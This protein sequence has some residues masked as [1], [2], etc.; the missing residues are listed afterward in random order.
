MEEAAEPTQACRTCRASKPLSEFDVRADTGKPSTQ[1]RDCRRDY[2]REWL[3]GQ[4]PPSPPR[5]PRRLGAADSFLCSRCGQRKP[6]SEFP[7]RKRG[8]AKLQSWCR[9][10]F[11][12][13]GARHYA[14][15][16][17]AERERVRRSR[18]R[19]EA[20]IRQRLTSA[21][22]DR[23]C[24]DCGER[25]IDRLTFELPDRTMTF[26]GLVHS[27]WGWE[28]VSV[29]VS[30][31][32]IRC[33]GCRRRNSRPGF[34][35][36]EVRPRTRTT[37]YVSLN[38]TPEGRIRAR[39]GELKPLEDFA[40]KYRG[41]RQPSSYCRGCQSK[42][43]KEW[44]Q[45]NRERVTA[46]V[47]ANRA[48]TESHVDKVIVRLDVR[49][50]RWLHLLEHPCVD[51]GESDPLVLEF[52]HR[53]EKRAGVNELMRN[54]RTWPE[55]SAEIEKCDVRCANCHRRRTASTHGYYEDL[56]DVAGSIVP[57]EARRQ[58][59][60]YLLAHPCVDCGETDPTVLE[61]DHRDDKRAAIVDLMRSHASWTDVVAEIQKCDVRCANCHRRRTAT[62]RGHYRE[63]TQVKQSNE[64]RLSEP[65]T[66]PYEVGRL[67]GFA[68]TPDGH[69]PSTCRFEVCRSIQLSYGVE[70]IC[71]DAARRP[72]TG[73]IRRPLAS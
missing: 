22:A 26:C 29:V 44:Y 57:L 71:V 33:R 5:S 15:N 9:S 70:L 46:R 54:H 50:R 72:R 32:V 66:D 2:Q 6:A 14:E 4:R 65:Q 52:D 12:E 64:T 51:C 58:R 10:C 1:C 11:A 60:D 45:E 73:T 36:R 53:S 56:L 47:R 18:L 48:R 25:D 63:L 40:P 39:C 28:K 24:I 34:T 35:P 16:A 43:H 31:C 38:D 8:D 41:L 21:L 61:F 55:I 30:G 3:R 23:P 13:V 59:W 27:G 62:T 17:D 68:A 49:R 67:V 7:P 37:S 20:D 19:R 69:D 42:Y